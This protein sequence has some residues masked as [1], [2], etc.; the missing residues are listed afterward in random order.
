MPKKTLT[1]EERDIYEKGLNARTL[2]SD[3]IMAAAINDL[4]NEFANNMLSTKLEERREREDF[5]LLHTVLYRLV[6]H[7]KSQAAQA[8]RMDKEMEEDEGET[9]ELELD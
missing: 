9:G 7:L 2:L 1:P 4:S 5:F 6:D 3:P 8:D